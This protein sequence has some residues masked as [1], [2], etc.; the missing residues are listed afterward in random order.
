[1][2]EALEPGKEVDLVEIPL[3]WHLDD[4]PPTMFVK[5]SPNSHGWVT[6]QALG[7]IWLDHFDWIY[8]TTTMRSIRLFFIPM[9][10]ENPM[11]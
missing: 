2:D 6:G 8:R 4:A 3:S 9:R 1:M 5:T 7:Q 10:L 11:S